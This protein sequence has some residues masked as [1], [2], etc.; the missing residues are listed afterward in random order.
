MEK[1]WFIIP[2]INNYAKNT[3]PKD[4]QHLDTTFQ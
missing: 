4:I 2:K 1:E 3:K